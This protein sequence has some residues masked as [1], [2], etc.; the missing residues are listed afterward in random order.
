V[1]SVT[2]FVVVVVLHPRIVQKKYEGQWCRRNN[3]DDE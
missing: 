3:D 1:A 2:V